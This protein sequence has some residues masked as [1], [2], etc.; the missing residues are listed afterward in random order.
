MTETNTTARDRAAEVAA[1]CKAAAA[2]FEASGIRGPARRAAWTVEGD[3]NRQ[4]DRNPEISDSTATRTLFDAEL[5]E[6]AELERAERVRQSEV[7]E[8]KAL[9]GAALLALLQHHVHEVTRL[10]DASEVRDLHAFCPECMRAIELES[11]RCTTH[12]LVALVLPELVGGA[13]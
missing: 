7:H 1:V 5:R 9:A 4:L 10:D 12:S 8:W 6:Q 3:A 2:H 13:S 11:K